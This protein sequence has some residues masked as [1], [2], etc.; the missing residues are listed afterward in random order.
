MVEG[1]EI[2]LTPSITILDVQDMYWGN[3]E[4]EVFTKV[5]QVEETV[6]EGFEKT[7]EA[8]MG[9]FT[10]DNTGKMVVKVWGE[11]RKNLVTVANKTSNYTEHNMVNPILNYVGDEMILLTNTFCNGFLKGLQRRWYNKCFMGVIVF[12]KPVLQTRGC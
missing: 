7:P 11:K 4:Q 1:K 6:V 10:G 5:L 12:P 3:L 2:V 9:L 8:F